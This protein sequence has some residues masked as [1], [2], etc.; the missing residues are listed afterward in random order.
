[1]HTPP[2]ILS[3]AGSDPSGGAGI[4]ADIKAVSALGG[5]AAAAV[6]AITAQNTRGVTHVEYLSPETVRCQCEAVLDDLQPDA[7][8]IGM[9]GTPDI[10]RA[11]SSVLRKY[12]CRNVVF[13]PVAVSTSG[14]MLTQPDAVDAACARLFPLCRLVTPNLH[15]AALLTGTTVADHNGMCRAA[16]TLYRRYGCAFLIKGGHLDGDRLTDVLYDG[17]LHLWTAGRIDTTNLHGTGCTLSSAIATLLGRG[18]PLPDAVS[19]ARDYLTAAIEAARPLAIGGGNGPLW[20]F[21]DK[22][23]GMP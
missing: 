6:T 16:E 2:V 3:I 9:V 23:Y 19:G 10:I 8:K 4:Q 17:A 12:A 1:M 13:D 20:H 15:E 18:F 22:K 5:Y 14:R 11:I 7:V 21:P